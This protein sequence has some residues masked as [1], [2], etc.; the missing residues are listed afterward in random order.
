MDYHYFSWFLIIGGLA[1]WIASVWVK[2]SGSGLLMD[3]FVGVIG[4]F[5][6][7][8]LAYSINAAVYG[9]WGILGM[10]V[11]GAIALLI[12]LRAFSRTP[13]TH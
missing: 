6:G 13:R 1:G 11:F 2:G 3:I 9:F 7:G 10:S 4:G 5:V 12:I 8:V